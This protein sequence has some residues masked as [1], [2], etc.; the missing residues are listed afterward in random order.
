MNLQTKPGGCRSPH[1]VPGDMYHG[2][3]QKG[4]ARVGGIPPIENLREFFGRILGVM[5]TLVAPFFS[6]C[7]P[8]KSP[9]K[10]LSEARSILVLELHGIG[11]TV[12]SLPCYHALR[13]HIRNARIVAIAKP[14]NA[15]IL[16]K[17]GVVDEVV[18]FDPR[19]DVANRGY[20]KGA[21]LGFLSFLRLLRHLL[22]LHGRIDLALSLYPDVRYWW[23]MLL[24]G[25]R[26]RVSVWSDIWRGRRFF[27][28]KGLLTAICD[29]KG[30]T[31]YVRHKVTQLRLLGVDAR[32]EKVHIPVTERQKGQAVAY[33]KSLGVEERPVILVHPGASRPKK[34]W[35]AKNFAQLLQRL[36]EKRFGR[37]LV[38]GPQEEEFVRE[39]CALLHTPPAVVRASLEK[40]VEIAAV[41]DLVICHDSAFQHIANAVGTPVIALYGPVPPKFNTPTGRAPFLA[42]E[43]EGDFSC[44]P[45]VH[46][47]CPRKNR[48]IDTI[49]VD[50]VIGAV[51]NFLRQE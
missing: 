46:L 11:D 36:K 7:K 37:V 38:C 31:H 13:R 39:I 3:R 32:E 33:L 24:S 5:G 48:C 20:L 4:H 15:I 2:V 47:V 50:R 44:R 40:V 14:L 43:P 28:W 17:A 8:R 41:A 19:W 6:G 26:H 1:G 18:E 12:M 35:A 42:L 22:E 49:A 21:L 30:I 10:A 23:L 45:C 27:V 34:R 9:S 25:A 16:R 29:I 51:E